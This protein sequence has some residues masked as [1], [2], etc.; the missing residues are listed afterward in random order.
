[1]WLTAV[2][3]V[4]NFTLLSHLFTCSTLYTMLSRFRY[5]FAAWAALLGFTNPPHSHCPVLQLTCSFPTLAQSPKMSGKSS[6]SI[7]ILTN[8]THLQGPNNIARRST[9]SSTNTIEPTPAVPQPSVPQH[10][11]ASQP[12][13]QPPVVPQTSRGKKEARAVVVVVVMASVVVVK[14]VARYTHFSLSYI[15]Y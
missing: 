14:V 9:R 10:S 3:G 5:M 11:A 12:G 7:I 1:M 15:A 8:L 6:G 13:F 2:C 4:S